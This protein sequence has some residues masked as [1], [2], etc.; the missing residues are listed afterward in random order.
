M[1]AF[2][3]IAGMTRTRSRELFTAVRRTSIA[4]VNAP[5]G[6]IRKQSFAFNLPLDDHLHLD[7][8]NGGLAGVVRGRQSR[9]HLHGNQSPYLL[10]VDWDGTYCRIDTVI[11]DSRRV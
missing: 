11:G 3:G 5:F 2:A 7:P 6:G 10:V 1:M 8:D 4:D 9:I